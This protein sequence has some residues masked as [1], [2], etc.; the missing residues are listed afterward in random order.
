LYVLGTFVKNQVGVAVWIHIWVLYSV[1]LVF[2]TVFVP[3]PCC[4]FIAMAL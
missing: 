3:V 2:M 1:L 4:F